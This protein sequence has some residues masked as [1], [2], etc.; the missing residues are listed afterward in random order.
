MSIARLLVHGLLIGLGLTSVA[1]AQRGGHGSDGRAL[2]AGCTHCHGMPDPGVPGGDLWIDRVKT[3]ACV[4]PAGKA[5]MPKRKALLGYLRAKST[6]RPVNLAKRTEPRAGQGLV[7][8]SIPTGSVL[9]LP[10]GPANDDVKPVRLVFGDEKGN[11]AQRAMPVGTWRVR[12]YRIQRKDKKGVT[13]QLWGSGGKG[14]RVEVR[15]GETTPL[16]LD[17]DVRVKVTARGGRRGFRVGVGVTGDS[18]MGVTV[19]RAQDRVP[20]G[21][22]FVNGDRVLTK[23]EMKYG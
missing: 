17:V 16:P 18:Q 13:W 20:A 21:Y 9:L 6:M 8:C 1:P 14:R 2:F 19:V 4:A 7:T 12:S 10:E 15:A 11:A 5:G 3:T 22:A 23:G